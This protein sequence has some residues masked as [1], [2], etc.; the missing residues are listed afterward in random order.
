MIDPSA[1]QYLEINGSDFVG[2]KF[3]VIGNER[4]D[5]GSGVLKGPIM[6]LPTLLLG[7]FGTP[8]SFYLNSVSGYIPETGAVTTTAPAA[9]NGKVYAE[10]YTLEESSS[11]PEVLQG[12][13]KVYVP[14]E[15]FGYAEVALLVLQVR[16]TGGPVGRIE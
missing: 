3:A 11:I 9:L 2:R 13:I 7:I 1:I 12:D 8:A 16:E 10:S 14:G 6:P 5:T 15:L 4:V